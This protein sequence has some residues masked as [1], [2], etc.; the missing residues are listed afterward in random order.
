MKILPLSL[1]ALFG[2]WVVHI[3]GVFVVSA[4]KAAFL[5]LFKAQELVWSEQRF[6]R[7]A[8]NGGLSQF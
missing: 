4:D 1:I 2:V 6:S 5:V 7:T 8:I 3:H